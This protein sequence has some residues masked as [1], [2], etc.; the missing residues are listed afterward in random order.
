MKKNGTDK[1]DVFYIC[2]FCIV[3]AFI[4]VY[5]AFTP[6]SDS[7]QLKDNTNTTQ[8]VQN[9]SSRTRDRKENKSSKNNK[10]NS[11]K[12][13]K[14]DR[15][16]NINNNPECAYRMYEIKA[17]EMFSSKSTKE[18][19]HLDI[20]NI[21]K[22]IKKEKLDQNTKIAFLFKATAINQ[23]GNTHEV[24][25]FYAET[26]VSEINKCN[27][28]YMT[29]NDMDSILFNKQDNVDKYY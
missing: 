12:E 28:E 23:Y 21:C 6:R 9:N 16:I 4:G 18:S 11:E 19:I 14:N 29:L 26:T 22:D 27:F 7:K 2:L 1:L 5:I 20:Q 8:I 24:K 13:S 10:T 17:N 3:A 25:L 15:I